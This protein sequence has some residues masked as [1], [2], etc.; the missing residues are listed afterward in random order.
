MGVDQRLRTRLQSSDTK[1]RI[2]LVVVKSAALRIAT[3]F[4]TETAPS[5]EHGKSRLDAVVMLLARD[6]A[7]WL[8]LWPTFAA[9]VSSGYLLA[10]YST[11]NPIG[12]SGFSISSR[13]TI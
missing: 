6:P 12:L 2:L 8:P 13:S 10:R 5:R 11:M 7:R 3:S 4:G 9:L 1:L